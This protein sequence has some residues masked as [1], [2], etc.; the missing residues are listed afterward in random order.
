MDQNNRKYP[1]D[2]DATGDVISWVIVFILMFAFWPVGLLLLFRKLRGY[3]KPAA[4]SSAY[5]N[6]NAQN[7]NSWQQGATQGAT[8]GAAQGATQGATQRST[9]G[10]TQSYAGAARNAGSSARQAAQEAGS[11]ARQAASQAGSAARQAAS[12]A[13]SA[14]RQAALEF[15]I[16]ARRAASRYSGYARKTAAETYADIASDFSKPEK[17]KPK[18][19]KNTNRLEK[20]SGKFIS[21]VLL[22]IAIA[23]LIIGANTIA[24]AAQDI[25]GSGLNSWRDFW[26][27]IFYFAGAF[28]SFFS[29][30]IGVR[31][32]SRYKK[33]YAFVD[34]RGVV[35]M[36]D[37]A[38]TSGQSVRVVNRDIQAMINDGYFGAEA[39]IDSELDSLVL[40]AQAAKE[41]RQAMYAEQ[42]QPA[43]T[44]EAPVNQYMSIILELRALND[45]IV[46]IAISDKIDRIEE[47][48]AKIFRIV[49]DSPSKLPQIR[50][51]M[52]Y[53][54]P[55]TL[56]LLHSYALLEKQGIKGENI[57]AAKENISRILDTLATGYEQQLDQ[58]FMSDVIDIAADINV[59]ENLMHQ[60][61][62][63]DDK[64]ELRTDYKPEL[65][66]DDKPEL[67]ADDKPELAADDK[68]E[69]R[70]MEST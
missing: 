54:L 10:S 61:G 17:S 20:K 15:E 3:A 36:Q 31:R 2:S 11:A 37:I 19:K 50:R 40:Y 49:E 65:A 46:D 26:M 25:W 5:Y 1:P 9:Q 48:T 67:V 42:E 8:Q 12:Q 47:L 23:L 21:T 44:P 52:N 7:A 16:A 68:P 34:G 45:T 59:L 35:P 63:T 43:T 27:G 29:R 13:G 4:K 32:F 57:T 51:F 53:Y 58:L 18:K 69:L 56:K 62:L 55:T 39:Y 64:P 70:T 14:A 30:N 24:R 60:D 22:L 33:Y 41:A 66:V 38:R 28:I 6:A